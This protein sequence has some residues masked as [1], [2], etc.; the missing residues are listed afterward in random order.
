[1]MPT[2]TPELRERYQRF[3]GGD[4]PGATELWTDDFVWEADDSEL[5]GSGRHEGKQAA[6]QAVYEAVAAFDTFELTA[7][8][9]VEQDDTVVV[10]GHLDVRKGDRSGRLP[11]VH[12]WRCRDDG[13]S[14]V[15]ILND[16]LGIGRLL[17]LA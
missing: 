4:V 11:F 13:Y 10:L 14:R 6:I 2:R 1:M 12:V 15:Q 3:R 17:G 7:D 16:T 8:E 9:F 5:P